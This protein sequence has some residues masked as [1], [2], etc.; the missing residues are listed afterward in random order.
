MLRLLPALLWI[1]LFLHTTG[2]S[3][4]ARVDLGRVILSGRDGWQH[5]E[6]V[7]EALALRPGDR[8]AEIGAGRGYWVGRLAEAVGPEGR[9]YAVEVERELVEVLEARAARDGWA[10]VVVIHGDYD[11]PRLPDG[12]V[13]LALTSLTYHHIGDRVAY[14]ERL[15]ADLAPGGRVAHLDDRPDA[16]APLSWFQS[17]GHWSVPEAITTEMEAA[18]YARTA[19]FDFLPVQS[20]QVFRPVVTVGAR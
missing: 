13:D 16:P 11:D 15:R 8:I 9:V 14:F 2:C 5:P 3:G 18:G 12:E 19:S 6:R 20:F 1:L 10:N 4:T 17:E 7:I